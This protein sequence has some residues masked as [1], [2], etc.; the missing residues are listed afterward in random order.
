MKRPPAPAR[1]LPEG[2]QVEGRLDDIAEAARRVAAKLRLAHVAQRTLALRAVPAALLVPRSHAPR[3]EVA[4]CFY[5]R[6]DE[7]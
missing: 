5:V 4:A 6:A 2:S 3:R 1:V 7:Q